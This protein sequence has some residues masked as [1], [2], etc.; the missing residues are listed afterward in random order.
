[1]TLHLLFDS[2]PS[3]LS[4]IQDRHI[5]TSFYHL[6]I[7][8]THQPKMSG[9]VFLPLLDPTAASLIPSLALL[10]PLLI[11]S[12]LVNAILPTY[13]LKLVITSNRGMAMI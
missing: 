10:G 2:Y 13:Q 4:R 9:P 6:Y 11:P 8:Y 1:M 5:D 3:D 7:L 12:D